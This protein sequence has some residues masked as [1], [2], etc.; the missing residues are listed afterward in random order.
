VKCL[1]FDGVNDLMS[2]ASITGQRSIS[3]VVRITAANGVNSGILSDTADDIALIRNSS[4]NWGAFAPGTGAAAGGTETAGAWHLVSIRL[5]AT[6]INIYLD[7]AFLA[8]GASTGGTLAS[9]RIGLGGGGAGKFE[10]AEIITWPTELVGAD[11]V[12]V[13]NELRKVYTTLP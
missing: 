7:G 5:S 6:A 11:F 4:N 10:V 9:L 3:I 2:L 8:T 12:T 1:S 13:Q